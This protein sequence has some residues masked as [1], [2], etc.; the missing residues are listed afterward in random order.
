MCWSKKAIKILILGFQEVTALFVHT[1]TNDFPA[2]WNYIL[3][4]LASSEGQ[5]NWPVCP[6]VTPWGRCFQKCAD[7]KNALKCFLRHLKKHR[8]KLHI[9]AYMLTKWDYILL[10]LHIC[11][12]I[13]ST[14]SIFIMLQKLH[15]CITCWLNGNCILQNLHN[16]TI[17]VD[18]MELSEI[19]KNC[20]KQL[21]TTPAFSQFWYLVGELARSLTMEQQQ[22]TALILHHSWKLWQR[23]SP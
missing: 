8:W 7:F 2:S 18:W 22:V 21:W 4:L 5:T 3:L 17:H 13:D 16:S 20:R 11:M 23:I 10:K 12:H 6:K 14:E 9:F 1:K 19:Q 15:S